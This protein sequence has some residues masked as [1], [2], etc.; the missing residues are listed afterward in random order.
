[1]ENITETSEVF[2]V[3]IEEVSRESVLDRNI[4]Y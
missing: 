1:M 4:P 2:E 3:Q